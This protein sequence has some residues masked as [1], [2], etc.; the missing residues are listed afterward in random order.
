MAPSEEWHANGQVRLQLTVIEGMADLQEAAQK[1]W[2]F[3]Q[4]NKIWDEKGSL[5]AEISYAKGVLH[6]NSSYFHDNGTP[7]KIIPYTNDTIEG[8]AISYDDHGNI[9][10]LTHYRQ[11]LREGMSHGYFSENILKFQE[12]YENDLLLEASYYSEDGKKIAEI[13]NGNGYQ[14]TY[15]NHLL[16]SLVQFQKGLPKGKVDLFDAQGKKTGTLAS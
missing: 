13:N 6:G 14:A 5:M 11:G 3:D 2:V 9:I 7:K 4:T 8:D 15:E 1:T 12:K 16:S 10:E